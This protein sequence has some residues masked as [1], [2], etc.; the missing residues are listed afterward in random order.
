MIRDRYAPRP[1]NYRQQRQNTREQELYE[2]LR[3]GQLDYLVDRRVPLPDGLATQS[4]KEM[5]VKSLSKILLGAFDARYGL[6]GST[7]PMRRR[8]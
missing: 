1:L 7:P 6:D 3:N 5:A 2:A 8:W 4:D